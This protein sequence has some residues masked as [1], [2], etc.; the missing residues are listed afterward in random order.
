VPRPGSEVR[1][2]HPPTSVIRRRTLR[3]PRPDDR[4]APAGGTNPGPLSL[5]VK[6]SVPPASAIRTVTGAPAACLTALLT[7]SRQQRHSALVDRRHPVA[8]G[9]FTGSGKYRIELVPAHVDNGDKLLRIQFTTGSAMRSAE[10][11][12]LMIEAVAVRRA[13]DIHAW[14]ERDN[15]PPTEFVGHDNEE[16][17]ISVPG[18]ADA[19]ITVGAVKS[20]LPVRVGR[21]SSFGPTR[22]GR[23]KPDLCAPDVDIRAA[24]HGSG[25]GVVA[26]CGTSQAAPHVAGAIA[27]LL[28]KAKTSG[29]AVPTASQ[30]RAILHNTTRFKN[31]YWDRGQG[32]GALDVKALMEEGLRTLI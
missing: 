3:S 8:E 22:D 17:T 13:G 7:D 1:L 32:F 6:R 31:A 18:T 12:T 14:I 20:A 23:E 24:F 29:A 15:A 2:S 30:I 25:D 21:F 11:W 27:L 26:M 4:S 5:M 9:L 16:M 10:E 28:S 19:G